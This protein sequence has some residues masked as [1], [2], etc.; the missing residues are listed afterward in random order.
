[1]GA[2]APLHFR[3]P[4]HRI[5]DRLGGRLWHRRTCRLGALMTPRKVG[6]PRK[7]RSPLPKVTVSQAPEPPS[8]AEQTMAWLKSNRDAL[9]V[10]AGAVAVIVLAFVVGLL[11]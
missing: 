3:S 9:I 7:H 2:V 6:L 10:G 8:A 1:M 5:V 11:S 4:A